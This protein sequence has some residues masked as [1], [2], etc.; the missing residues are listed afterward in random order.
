MLARAHAEKLEP[1]EWALV[2]CCAAMGWKTLSPCE[3]QSMSSCNR[4]TRVTK[5]SSDSTLRHRYLTDRIENRCSN[6]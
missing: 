2:Q 4:E 5:G 3:K 1:W 6:K